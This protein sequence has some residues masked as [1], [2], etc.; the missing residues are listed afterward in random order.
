MT[1]ITWR[2]LAA[3]LTADQVKELTLEEQQLKGYANADLALFDMARGHAD[4]NR[5]DAQFAHIHAPAG[6]RVFH[7][8]PSPD[9]WRREVEGTTRTA[10]GVSA[11]VS[12]WQYSDGRVEG[13]VGID[14]QAHA[15]ELTAAQAREVAAMMVEAAAEA[16][17]LRYR[18]VAGG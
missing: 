15:G 5:A 9:G 1:S 7:W 17:G 3:D 11:W 4:A 2:D 6:V 16:E 8:Q 14:A 18:A 13:L 10:H 12:G